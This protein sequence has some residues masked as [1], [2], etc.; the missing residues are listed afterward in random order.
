MDALEAFVE[1]LPKVEL[2]VHLVG[3]ASRETVLELARRHPEY[4]VPTTEAG[5][6]V[7][8]EFVDFRHFINVY[9]LI[10]NLVR[11][12]E[13]ITALIG[14]IAKDLAAQ[15]VR[16]SEM[17]V[18]LYPWWSMGLPARVI[19]EALDVAA[20]EALETHGVRFAYIFDFRGQEGTTDAPRTLDHALTAPPEKL[21]GFGVGGIEADRAPHMDAIRS[22]FSAAAA[23][24]LRCVP[25]AGETTG[26]DS[27]WEAIEY[28]RADRIGHGIRA[29]EDPSL[30][31]YLAERQLPLDVSPTSN[32]CTRCVP[33][34]DKH[35]L[36]RMI[37]SGLFVTLNSDDPPMFGTTLSN[38]YLVAAR[39]L[40]FAPADL[41]ALA[42]NGV[43]ASFLDGPSKSA[44]LAEIASVPLPS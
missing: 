13:D 42:A 7:F 6:R 10:S 39:D 19:T 3:S 33:S 15:N 34:I 4:G 1:A 43:R 44:L 12:P 30:V 8:Y 35:P 14:G 27:V 24:G 5:L 25:H 2:H 16:Y 37:R 38:E 26:P 21:I 9:R 40:G 31:S 11:E 18:S 23:Y 17:Q 36:R 29:L 28:L 22:A 32:V 20:R 41:A